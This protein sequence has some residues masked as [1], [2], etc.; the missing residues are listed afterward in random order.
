MWYGGSQRPFNEWCSVQSCDKQHPKSFSPSEMPSQID[1]IDCI[2]I[3]LMEDAFVILPTSFWNNLMFQ[4][5]PRGL[6]PMDG[7]PTQHCL[8]DHGDMHSSPSYNERPRC[9]LNKNR[10]HSIGNRYWQRSWEELKSARL[11]VNMV[12]DI[13]TFAVPFL[14][15]NVSHLCD[16]PCSVY[17]LFRLIAIANY[18]LNLC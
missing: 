16:L 2:K 18:V 17:T 7:K 4:L 15:C 10:S 5:F 11:C 12:H 13:C 8:H 14:L 9:Q 6:S 3:W 1:Q